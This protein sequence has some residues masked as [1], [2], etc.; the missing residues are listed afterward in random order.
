MFDSQDDI[1]AVVYGPA[2]DPDRLLRA[3]AD[4]LQRTG[5][6]VVGLLQEGRN[7]G[8][9]PGRLRAVVLPTRATVALRHDCEA[10]PVDCHLDAGQVVEVRRAIAVAIDAGAD[11]VIINRFGKL[12]AAGAGFV[13]EIER[14]VAAD[15]PVLIA[16]PHWRFRT[17]TRF[18]A[19]MA[20]KLACAREPIDTWWRA[21]SRRSNS[22]ASGSGATFCAIAK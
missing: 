20:V 18:C 3:F 14:A 22:A 10:A 19:G 12:E 9:A 16:V 4:D 5:C 17:W 2:D 6:R 15:V 1:A 8:I 11:L 21:A 13:E 7:A